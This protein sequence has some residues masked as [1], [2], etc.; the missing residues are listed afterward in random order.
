MLYCT[1]H[2]G[3]LH[4]TVCINM[5]SCGPWFEEEE[6]VVKEEEEVCEQL[7][8]WTYGIVLVSPYDEV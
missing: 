7:N 6:N 2:Y 5:V 8:V 1:S 4:V 3:L